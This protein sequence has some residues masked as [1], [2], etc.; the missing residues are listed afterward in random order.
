MKRTLAALVCF[1]LLCACGTS[2][3]VTYTPRRVNVDAWAADT[4]RK[5][6]TLLHFSRWQQKQLRRYSV[7]NVNDM[8]V[9]NPLTHREARRAA[10]FFYAV[11]DAYWRGD[12]A[13]ERE[14][15]LAMRGREPF[16]RCAKGY[17]Y[18]WWLRDLIDN[19]SPQLGG[20]TISISK[21]EQPWQRT[22]DL[23]RPIHRGN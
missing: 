2:A 20:F 23:K 16:F 15:L 9:K 4:G 14:T 11:M 18:E 19:A 3:A 6:R 22:N 12:L 8:C 7:Q 21:G 17:A 10:A 5:D 1:L 13:A